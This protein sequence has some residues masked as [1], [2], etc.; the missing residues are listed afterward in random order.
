MRKLVLSTLSVAVL[1][2]A[3]VLA[4]QPGEQS[5][6]AGPNSVLNRMQK[7]L[8]SGAASERL[9]PARERGPSVQSTQ[10]PAASAG[11]SAAALTG[12][13]VNRGSNVRVNQNCLNLTDPDLQGRGQAQNETAIAQ[14]P[15]RPSRLVAGANDYR[16]GDGN[17]I[18]YD[19]S[20]G[21]RSWQDSIPPTSFTRGDA[22]G[23]FPRQYW[24]GSGDPSVAWD[25]K[26]NAYVSCQLFNRGTSVTENPD[27]SSSLVVFRSTQ[28]GGRSWNFPARP[29]AEAHDPTGVGAPFLDK[30]YM[31]VDNHAGSPFQDRIYVTWT[32]FAADGTAYIFS[33]FSKDYGE[34]FSAPALVSKD[35]ALCPVDAGFP[36]PQGRCNE[37]QDSQPFTGPD[38][39]LYV[40]FDNFNVTGAG[41]QP[42]ATGPKDNR[43]QVLL[44]K[45]TDGG[46]T[47]SAPVKVSDYYDLPDCETYQGQDPG[48]SCVPE[49]GST[50]NSFFRATNYPSA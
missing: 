22:F 30:Q 45:S 8:L 48:R 36:T 7:R 12:C 27:Q 17:C 5:A 42:E 6:Q 35:S 41:I 16:R 2:V 40:A 14:D 28:S 33:S 9:A 34:T 10:R 19:S 1:G 4:L 43:S 11:L 18:A 49:K 15:N 13:P 32:L 23:G 21:G 3:A 29:V 44:V 39:A 26:G 46:A 47:F 24:E 31:T 37:N 25:T 20:T 50:Q 38:G